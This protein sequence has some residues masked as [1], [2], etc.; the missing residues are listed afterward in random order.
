M[1]I[2][3]TFRNDFLTLE[4][5]TVLLENVGEFNKQAFK[6]NLVLC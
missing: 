2:F 5:S 1:S 4:K 3:N 6:P